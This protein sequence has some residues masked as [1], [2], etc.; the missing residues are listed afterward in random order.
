VYLRIKMVKYDVD[1]EITINFEKLQRV[2]SHFQEYSFIIGQFEKI[3]CFRVSVLITL[4]VIEATS[5]LLGFWSILSVKWIL[6]T[7]GKKCYLPL[8][9][10][11]LL[12]NNPVPD[13]SSS[14]SFFSHFKLCVF[15]GVEIDTINCIFWWKMHIPFMNS[16]LLCPGAAYNQRWHKIKFS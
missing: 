12:F 10:H 4:K 13:L 8:P 14:R 5:I 2:W 1:R 9:K 11:E 16:T 6:I 7:N 15:I 3:T